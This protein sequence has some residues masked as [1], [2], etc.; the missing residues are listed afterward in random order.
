MSEQTE[1]PAAPPTGSEAAAGRAAQRLEALTA[2][3][4]PAL[5]LGAG[6]VLTVVNLVVLGWMIT[7]QN[8]RLDQI[9]RTVSSVSVAPNLTS[10][11]DLEACWLVGASAY[12]QGKDEE[13][14]AQLSNAP[15]MSDCIMRAQQG[16]TGQG[17]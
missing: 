9:E 6:I 7:S 3:R 16:A 5:G 17:R 14:V 4:R 15:T 1:Q 12:A 11:T 8:D 13:F 10:Q 2:A